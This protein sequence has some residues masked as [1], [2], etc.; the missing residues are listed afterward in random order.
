MSSARQALAA[1]LPL[2]CP[3]PNPSLS[4]PLPGAYTTLPSSHPAPHPTRY[5][6]DEG[7]TY[8][9]GSATH[10]LVLYRHPRSRA[11][12][13]GAGACQWSWGLDGHH[14][15]ANGGLDLKLGQ[16]CYSLR[17]GVDP[18][19]PAERTIQ[20]ATVNL[21][22][23]M[24][25]HPATPQPDLTT[26]LPS[27]DEL[28]PTVHPIVAKHVDHLAGTTTDEGG[29][30]VA[31]VEVLLD[32]TGGTWWPAEVQPASGKWRLSATSELNVELPPAG[33]RVKVRATDDSGNLS[34][35]IEVRLVE[36]S[37]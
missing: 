1:N 6:F 5:I 7:S 37:S 36:G 29:G 20:Q 34:A 25:V 23:D 35:E 12:V 19:R 22:A 15:G 27:A 24:G 21:F 30:V 9:A 3:R 31:A 13:F 18:L 14:D 4:V 32:H 11:L 10:H 26:S 17:V 28:P 2:V 8:D 16:N 33:T